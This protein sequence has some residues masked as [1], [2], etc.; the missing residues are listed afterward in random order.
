MKN[1]KLCILLHVIRQ[2]SFSGAIFSLFYFSKGFTIGDL[3]VFLTATKL[4]Q[5]ILEIPCSIFADKFGRK[6]SVQLSRL[7][8]IVEILVLVFCFSLTAMVIAALIEG[9]CLALYSDSDTSLVYDNLEKEGKTSLYP[10]FIATYNAL[11]YLSYGIASV[12]GA[13]LATLVPFSTIVMLRI[14][15][16]ILHMFLAGKL[17]D[18]VS[19]E[20]KIDYTE[21]T[22]KKR[23]S[24]LDFVHLKEGWK[25]IIKNRNI[26]KIL[27]FS[28]VIFAFNH[29]TWDY[30]QVYGREIDLPIAMFG[31]VALLFAIAQGI[32]QF[33]SY[34]YVKPKNFSSLFT[35]LI[36]LA[37]VLMV[38]SALLHNETGFIFLILSVVV[39]GFSFPI[40]AAIIHKHANTEHRITISSIG[41]LSGM[42]LYS[43]YGLFIGTIASDSDNIFLA[44]GF[45]AM[46]TVGAALLYMIMHVVRPLLHKHDKFVQMMH[47]PDSILDHDE[48]EDNDG[49]KHRF[50]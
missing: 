12:I 11:G 48:E 27:Y 24:H 18:R 21:I 23:P 5:A 4:S 2:F 26:I 47:I 28:A 49:Y 35:G 16:V 19:D 8:T 13:T 25:H 14:P 44:I 6:T 40:S 33:I 15:F 30:Y 45:V 1:A 37:A 42:L 10:K 31:W 17:I 41:T 22:V 39:S 36:A 32:P 34:K 38:I 50:R 3:A 43:V 9:F 29:V 7:L 46:I 20:L